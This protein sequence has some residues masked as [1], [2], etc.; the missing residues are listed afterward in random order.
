[1]SRASSL[2]EHSAPATLAAALFLLAA[3][4]VPFSTLEQI[5]VVPYSALTPP[6]SATTH[7]AVTADCLRAPATLFP[8]PAETHRLQISDVRLRLIIRNEGPLD[9]SAVVLV[10]PGGKDPYAADTPGRI[11]TPL[12]ALGRRGG[13]AEHTLAASAELLAAHDW[14]LGVQITGDGVDKPASWRSED[15]LEVRYQ[16]LAQAKIP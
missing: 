3:C 16:V 2:S 11:T 9:L 7:D 8:V 15:Y 10:T 6:A 5:V 1:M 4:T 14:N 13:R 12:L